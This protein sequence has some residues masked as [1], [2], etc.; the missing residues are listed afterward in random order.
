M[1]LADTLGYDDLIVSV[2]EPFPKDVEF[3][4]SAMEAGPR[5]LL[6]RHRFTRTRYRVRAVLRL[7]SDGENAPPKLLFTRSVSSQAVGFVTSHPLPLSHGGI[8]L[9]PKPRGEVEKV[10]CTVLRCRQAAP[11]WYEGAVYFNRPQECFSPD[12]LGATGQ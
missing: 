12:I 9:I 8:L 7:F 6:D 3:V 1:L 2:D 5:P 11:K 4:I 10:S